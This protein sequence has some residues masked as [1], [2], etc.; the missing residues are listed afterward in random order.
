MFVGRQHL[1]QHSIKSQCNILLHRALG[2]FPRRSPQLSTSPFLDWLPAAADATLAPVRPA[3][4]LHQSHS[5]SLSS[6]PDPSVI[7][8]GTAA[9]I[10]DSC[11]S[12]TAL[13]PP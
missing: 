12:R 8:P 9:P 5:R 4:P 11:A 3:R 10:R 2:V 6:L 1:C 7:S 13:A